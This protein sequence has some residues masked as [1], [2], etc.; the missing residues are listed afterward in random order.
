MQH[1][2]ATGELRVRIVGDAE[3]AAAH[4]AHLDNAATTDVITFDLAGPGEPIDAD[5][6]INLDEAVRQASLRG[7]PVRHELLLY[8]LHA[9]LHCAGENDTTDGD[10]ERMHRREDEVLA[11]IGLAP[12]FAREPERER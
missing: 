4:D 5:A 10:A 12:V 8:A 9:L 3:I 11:A 1:I 7:H 2:G 6:L